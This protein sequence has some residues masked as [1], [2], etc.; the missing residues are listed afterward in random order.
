MCLFQGE[1][2]LDICPRVGLLGHEYLELTSMKFDMEVSNTKGL[3]VYF[4]FYE[5]E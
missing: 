4:Y 3:F 5:S 2:C 1:F